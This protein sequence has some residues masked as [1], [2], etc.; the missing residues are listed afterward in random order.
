MNRGERLDFSTLINTPGFE[1]IRVYLFQSG[2]EQMLERLMAKNPGLD[3]SFL[4]KDDE[5]MPDI[6]PKGDKVEVVK[7]LDKV[8]DDAVRIAGLEPTSN[9]FVGPEQGAGPKV[10]GLTSNCWNYMLKA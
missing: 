1:E 10:M 6:E 4:D 3:L 8:V 7:G 2:Y 5:P 9:Q